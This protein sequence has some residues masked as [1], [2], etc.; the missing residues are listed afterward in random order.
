MA[1]ITL[2][3][4]GKTFEFPLTVG[5]EKEGGIDIGKLRSGSGLVT[6]DPGFVNTAST[7]SSITFLDGEKGILRY[8]GYPI[9]QL[10][11]HSSFVEVAYLLL[12]GE[13]P[14]AAQL[15]TFQQTL[16]ANSLV[17][18][19]LKHLY[20]A[21][22]RTAY[23]CV[24]YVPPE[25]G[26][27][28]PNVAGLVFREDEGSFLVGAVAGLESRTGHTGFVG[29]MDIPLIHRFEAGF[30]AGVRATCPDCATHVAYAGTTPDAFR[31]PAK[32]KALAVSQI[33]AGADVIFHASGTTGQGVFEAARQAGA[34][35]IGVD[36]DQHD[37]MPGTVLTSMIKRGDVAVFDTVAEV[38]D[39]R[40]RP[41]LRTFG[42][43]E[44]G[45]DFVREGPHAAGIAPA[46]LRRVAE[47]SQDVIAGRIAIP[48]R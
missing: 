37:E 30:R 2:T 16:A 40:F 13:L 41:G 21:F 34:R 11:E 27:I 44:K 24:D 33:A 31:D 28:P 36:A 39:H 19:D 25:G 45:V 1:N 17:P 15:A 14:S 7:T 4:D 46:T 32:G 22:P 6:L 5:S 35:A 18:E 10:A 3:H 23:A 43:A 38:V 26:A 9:E 8:R 12:H 29:G 20:R 42:L 47:L 48:T